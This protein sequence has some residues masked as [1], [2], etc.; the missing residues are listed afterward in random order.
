VGVGIDSGTINGG[1][2]YELT[3]DSDLAQ[4]SQD[5]D[6]TAA[7]FTKQNYLSVCLA[8]SDEK[9]NRNTGD[10][11]SAESVWQWYKV[12]ITSKGA[13]V[14]TA[15]PQL[16]SNYD[17]KLGLAQYL[18]FCD[19]SLPAKTRL[20]TTFVRTLI[21]EASLGLDSLLDYSLQTALLE[22]PLEAGGSPEAMDFN[23]SNGL[24][25]WELF[26]HMPFLVGWRFANE[27]QFDDAE[28][29][30]HYIFDPAASNKQP[31]YWNVRPLVQR[32]SQVSFM[33]QNALDPDTLAYANPEIYQ[34][35]VFLA[36][37]SNLVA[38]GDLWYRQQTRDGLTQ[39][40]V[41]YNLAAELLGPRP[42]VLLSS[43]WT[44][45]T[46]DTLST[47]PGTLDAPQRIPESPVRAFERS[48]DLSK[49]DI[50]ALP[51]QRIGY[52]QLADN[53]YF[54]APLNALLLAH[55]DTLDA[56][57]Y[58]LRHNLTV[59]G[60]PM[61]LSLYEAPADPLA[62]LVQRAQS[63]TL[64]NGIDGEQTV[65]PPYRF[66]ALLPR[67]YN[68]VATLS[69]FGENL[70]S[71][72]ERGENAGRE[73]LQQQQLLDMSSYGITLQNQAISGLAADQL[74]LTA[75][76][77]V[78]QNRYKSYYD[79]Y[80][81][82]ISS[83]EQNAMN[84]QTSAQSFITGAQGMMT[85]VGALKMVPNIFGTSDGGARYEGA[86]EAMA[87]ILFSTGQV[88]GVIAERL[89]TSENYRR[90]RQDWQ[91]QYQQAQ[92]Q[93]N[94][95]NK[96]L[97]ALAIRQKA[98]Q[99]ELKRLQAQQTQLQTMLNYLKDDRFTT[100]SLY[101][102]LN[103][104][105]AALYSQLYSSVLAECLSAQ[106][107]WQYELGDFTTTFIQPGG[108]NAHYRGL[109]V[110]DTLQLNLQQMESA[111]LA[112]HERRMEIVRTVSLMDVLGASTFSS[113][114]QSGQF[115]FDLTEEL[116]DQDY[117]GHY[118]RQIKSV[119]ISLPTLLG[120]YQDIKA[121]LTQ[122]QS[123]TLLNASLSGVQYLNNPLT[124]IGDAKIVT[125]LRPS[126]QI[127]LSS[128][129]ND[130]GM[131]ELN[132][133]DERYL[134]FEGTGA[135]SSWALKFPRYSK[136]NGQIAALA[137]LTD[138]I[139]HVRYTA[140]DGGESFTQAVEGTLKSQD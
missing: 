84:L 135:V 64:V 115:T 61:S 76:L 100:S 83:T 90:R 33:L 67:V 140:L 43:T 131:F 52:L 27:Q 47:P 125:N 91:I 35:A 95:V 82:D 30:L 42:D 89:Y 17:A 126:Q 32:E 15:L 108:W 72:I 65:I 127:A 139:V 73:E 74:S 9:I 19:D 58:N 37:V 81:E 50:P 25:F 132:F 3:K 62:L 16:K 18:D 36:Y 53:P 60:K 92:A 104:Q 56:R 109:L 28:Q 130:A 129:L 20:N 103:G 119:W 59:D 88:Q 23:G 117:P 122:T 112:R 101:Q 111:Y 5:F 134:P 98:A 44:P 49:A 1:S 10:L 137:A 105:L 116:F 93:V 123:S 136:S 120:P 106:A 86:M 8:I 77:A 22:A 45:Q 107:C 70:L 12:Y 75:S 121:V 63:G 113:Q 69:R 102:W 40:R 99:T 54:A 94:E 133:G 97:D 79:L 34:K 138:V 21:A 48:I 57:L 80:E 4:L 114:L 31:A 41:Y 14:P 124:G 39:A 7:D 13:S 68:A 51:G 78:S 66:S 24:Y 110:G 128:G 87:N 2:T 118:M 11:V 6:L 46:L 96:Q 55:W 26:F 71:L 29:W 38:Q 85:G